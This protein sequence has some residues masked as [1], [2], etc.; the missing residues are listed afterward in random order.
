MVVKFDLIAAACENMGIG[1][2]KDLPWRL[3]SEMAFFSRMT[4][5]TVDKNKKNVVLMG[6]KTWDCIPPKFKP[7]SNRINFIMS[8]SSV[9]VQNYKD[10]YSFTSLQE[11]LDTLGGE[12][13]QDQ[14]ENV[15]VIGGSYIYEETMK[16]KFFHRLYLTKIMKH[17]DCDTFFPKMKDNLVKISDS[18]V[19]EGIQEEN[20]IQ[21]V[22]NVYENP[23][24][25]KE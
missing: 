18:R 25:N 17:F 14:Y 9:D 2:N 22:Y 4:S 20:G 7:L 1:K 23:D 3:K 13:F 10:C 12:K 19:P 11:V 5:E 24:F 15:W 21:F 6:R 16:S 8:R